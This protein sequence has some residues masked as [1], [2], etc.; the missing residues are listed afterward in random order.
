MR[1]RNGRPEAGREG[2]RKGWRKGGNEFKRKKSAFNAIR[3]GNIKISRYVVFSE[4]P[5]AGKMERS[6]ETL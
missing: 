1:G 6:N 2:E 3:L 5:K 4:L